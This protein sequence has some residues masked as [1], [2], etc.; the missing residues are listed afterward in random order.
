MKYEPKEIEKKWQGRWE[1]SG[2]FKIDKDN[3]SKEKFYILDMFPYPSG[4]GLHMGHTESYT[5]SDVYYRF[6]KMQGY[7]V[8]HPQGFDSFGL[9]AE[10]YAIKTGVKPVETTKKNI[11]TYIEQMKSLGFDYDFDEKVITSDP[12]YYKWTQWIFGKFFENGLVYKKTQKTNWCSSCQT[13]IANEQVVNGECER[14]GTEIIQKE[15]P[16]WFFKI[17]DFS[18]ELIAGLSNV[19]WPE[20]TKKNQINWIGKSQG[21]LLKFQIKDS[22]K[23]IE[24]FTTR[25]DTLFGATYM[26]LAPEHKL[27]G[28][29]KDEI[30]NWSD[31]E[32]YVIQTQNKTE[33]DRMEAKEKTGEKLE[34]VVAIN[35]A[36]GQEIPI[37]IADYVLAGYGTG[38]IMAVPAH[39]ER[40]FEFAKKYDIPIMEVIS[41]GNV[42]EKAYIENGELINSGKFN[43]MSVE[44]AK[45]K[46]TEFVGGEM[47]ATY[48]LRDWSFSR[49]RYW[50]CPIPIVYSPEGEAK[51]V[52]EKY[53]PWTLPE[54][55]DFVPTGVAPLS[56]SE[57][58]KKR[59]E[60]IFGQ[61]WTAEYDTMDTFV[62]S[63]WYFLRYPDP[64]NEEK[65]C[66]AERLSKWMPVDLYIGGAEHTYMHLLYARF[67]TKA[68]HKIGLIDFDEPFL[69]LR[70]QG[71]VLDKEG[72]KMSKSKG[73][74]I[75][76][77]SMVE[78]FGADSVRTYMLFAAPLEDEVMWNEDNIVGV[79]RFLDR[80]WKIKQQTINNKQQTTENLK[81][82]TL[83]HKTIKKVSE[84]IENFRFNT[85]I[86]QMMILVNAMETCRSRATG[87]KEQLLSKS[88]YETLLILL[89]PFAPHI[90]EELWSSFAEATAD[91]GKNKYKESIFLQAW[92]VV[93]EKYLQDEEVEMV[94]QVNGKVRERLMV[95]HD[96]TEDEAKETAL[97]S[98]KVKVFTEGKEIKKII[99]VPGKLINI[100]VS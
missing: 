29:L 74:V 22:Q 61:G 2:S 56:K 83:L 89:S 27:V 15:V 85:A 33:L 21:A 91:E 66:S 80:V 78:K 64:H 50:G 40:D 17:T 31:V 26:V 54:D 76:P 30:F 52:P 81:I 4:T 39:D 67:I 44:E 37:F 12:S 23:Y 75:N 47:T 49:Q 43:G 8:L 73:N 51:L 36:N 19:D 7:N 14:C 58:L 55:V 59:V 16:G 1:K 62:D 84:D 35:P 45:Q 6:K 42:E 99:F 20:Y 77:D 69:K 79:R 90:A 72:K 5:A 88:H 24:V 9:P 100:V 18:D 71:M 97:E 34:G 94:V 93:D 46:I 3:E 48:R 53:L 96:V 98:S 13:V 95:A 25:P 68:M 10:N 32:K 65:F 63:S 70:H 92:P 60:D 87:E 82:Q 57:E 28:E 11:I 38:A 41:G 86:S